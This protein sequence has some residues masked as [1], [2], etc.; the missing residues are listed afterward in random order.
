MALDE[1][2]AENSLSSG[3]PPILRF[4]CWKPA[5]IS[6]GYNQPPDIVDLRRCRDKGIDV[7]RRPTGGR[8]ILH[9]EELTYSV[10]IPAN[11]SLFKR[12][13]SEI[14]LAVNRC[15]RKG[16]EV[17]GI[18]SS[19]SPGINRSSRIRRERISSL[20]FSSFARYEVRINGR[21]LIGSAQRK[22]LQSLLQHGSILMGEAHINIPD[23]LNLPTAEKSRLKE[24]LKVRT[25][26]LRE[27]KGGEVDITE[28]MEALKKGFMEEFGMEFINSAPTSEELLSCS[29]LIEKYREF[30]ICS[31]Y[32]SLK[33]EVVRKFRNYP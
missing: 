6:L 13:I 29:R 28:L 19:L 7:V 11:H 25:V 22:F 15:L 21:K 8:A 3:S 27:I 9:H 30:E 12:S 14:Y 33:T 10:I 16:L 4:F 24:I 2:L 1:S 18:K 31:S 32:Q 17:L 5:A 26:T 20:C 23:Y